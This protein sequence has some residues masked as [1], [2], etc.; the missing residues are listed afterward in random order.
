M[1]RVRRT[2]G[3]SGHEEIKV[4]QSIYQQTDALPS[5]AGSERSLVN[6]KVDCYSEQKKESRVSTVEVLPIQG[7]KVDV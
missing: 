2:G 4:E 6:W 5:V 1:S 3:R 7:K